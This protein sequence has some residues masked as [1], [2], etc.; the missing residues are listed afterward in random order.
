MADYVTGFQTASGIKKYDYHSLANLPESGSDITN[1]VISPNADY[2]EVGEWADGNPDRENRLGYFVAIAEVGDNTIKI[3][4]ATSTDDI[5][6]VSV[7]NPAFSGNASRDKYGEDGELLPQYNYIGLMGIV[8]IIDEGRC[9]VGGRCMS[10]DDGIAIPSKNNMGYAVLE[11]VDNRHILIAVEPGAD[12]IQRVKTDIVDIDEQLK[13]LNPS[14]EGL[15][16][17]ARPP[18]EDDAGCYGVNIGASVEGDVI[19]ASEYEGLPVVYIGSYAF[20]NQSNITSITMPSTVTGIGTYAFQNCTGLT[21]VVIPECMIEIQSSAFS[22]CSNLKYVVIPKGIFHIR[23][24][25][26][27][28]CTNLTDVYYEGTESEFSGIVS[29]NFNDPLFNAKIHYNYIRDFVTLSD[30]LG[31]PE[32]L[33]TES[34]E[35]VSAINELNNKINASGGG[36]STPSVS[37]IGT[38]TVIEN[39]EIPTSDISLEF[40]SNGTEY[41]GIGST[42]MG[43]SSWGINALSYKSAEGYYEAAYVNNPS[44]NYGI[45]HGWRNETYR[46]LTVTKEPESREAIAW[47]GDNTDAPKVELPK[48]EMPQI[49]FANFQDTVGGMIL[50][51][52]NPFTFTVEITGGGALKEG[53]LLQICVRRKYWNKKKDTEGEVRHKWKLRNV[54]QREITAEDIGKRFLSI[55]VTED[56]VMV[57]S[58]WMFR[59]DRKTT[60]V[61][62]HSYMYFR[63]KRVTKW[64]DI[65]GDE[66]DAI[67]SNVE[68]IAKT[69]NP[70]SKRL[71]IK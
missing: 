4:K 63:I 45:T 42:S 56:D 57:S 66:C 26:F 7:Y 9:T 65:T 41:I 19:I 69:Y 48:E 71:S 40:T 34:K 14:T 51:E 10:N 12:M 31:D 62:T 43:S 46:Y 15:R 54:L 29:K 22:G 37:L 5:R 67:F 17:A 44:G 21:S 49:R 33:E 20:Q 28:D 52:N 23:D 55:T 59:N 70:N 8:N 64:S 11:R 30:K 1:T 32:S 13:R 18:Y 24:R 25:V 39:P 36:S 2:A 53:D 50:K 60:N 58:K 16:Y 35:V 6:G 27:S 3:R 47:L 38:W 61:D 68:K